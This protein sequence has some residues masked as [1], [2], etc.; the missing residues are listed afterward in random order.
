MWYTI[1]SKG[2]RYDTTYWARD[3]VGHYDNLD[4]AVLNTIDREILL[5]SNAN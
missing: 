1:D 2:R 3:F 4:T 5:N